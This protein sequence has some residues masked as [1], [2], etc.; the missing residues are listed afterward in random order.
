MYPFGECS[1]F[2]AINQRDIFFKLLIEEVVKVT[3]LF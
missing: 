2:E 3:L 1:E